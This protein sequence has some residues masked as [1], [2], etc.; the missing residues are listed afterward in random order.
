M[1][2]KVK[3]DFKKGKKKR[4][5]KKRKRSRL[6]A[7]SS[8]AMLK[9]CAKSFSLKRVNLDVDTDDFVLNAYLFPLAVLASNQEKNRRLHINFEGVVILQIEMEIRLYFM[10]LA[11]IKNSIKR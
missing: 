10:V 9:A 5:K 11:I 3:P 8:R 6:K 2:L 1:G 4:K 7:F